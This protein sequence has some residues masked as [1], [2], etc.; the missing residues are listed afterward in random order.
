MSSKF[1]GDVCERLYEISMEG[2]DEEY[3]NCSEPP[4]RWWGLITDVDVGDGDGYIVHHAILTEDSQGFVDFED[5]ETEG[6]A[7]KDFA[8]I[9]DEVT[10]EMHEYHDDPDDDCPI[11]EEATS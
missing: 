11:C 4:C 7:R 9:V 10:K 8:R 1:G 6:D 3:G 2:C 5:Y